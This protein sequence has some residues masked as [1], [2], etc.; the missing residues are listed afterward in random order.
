MRVRIL[1]ACAL[2][3]LLL[4]ACEREKKGQSSTF[5][6]E[7]DARAFIDAVNQT[8][9]SRDYAAYSKFFAPEARIL[10]VENGITNSFKASGFVNELSERFRSVSSY[11]F[12][13]GPVQIDVV[14]AIPEIRQ[15]NRVAIE[16]GGLSSDISYDNTYYVSMLNGEIKIVSLETNV[17][18]YRRQSQ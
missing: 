10:S 17:S 2:F 13:P 1:L 9:R 11:E 15:M 18:V 6:S 12:F 7:G 3:F 14:G 16:Y 8:E 4:V 5:V